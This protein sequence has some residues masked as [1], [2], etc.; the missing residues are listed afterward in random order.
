MVFV[1]IKFFDDVLQNENENCPSGWRGIKSKVKGQV[2][3]DEEDRMLVMNVFGESLDGRCQ[4][5]PQDG[6]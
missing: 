2:S 1:L 4:G 5:R 3:S 6:K